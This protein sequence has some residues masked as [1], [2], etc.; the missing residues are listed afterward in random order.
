MGGGGGGERG[1]SLV[2]RGVKWPVGK[3]RIGVVAGGAWSF[4]SFPFIFCSGLVEL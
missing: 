4:A 3:R 2:A 1:F